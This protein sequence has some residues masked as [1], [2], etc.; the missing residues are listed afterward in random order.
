LRQ[1]LKQKLPEYM[2]PSAIVVLDEMPLTANGKVDRRA[3]PAPAQVTREETFVAPRDAIE[4]Q[5]AKLWIEML[6]L[7]Q[8]SVNDNFFDL[9]GHSL[10]A[11]RLVSRARETFHVELPLRS[12]FETATIA[13]MARAMIAHEAKPGQTEKIARFL[14]RLEAMS[15]EEVKL[16]HQKTAGGD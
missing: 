3:L 12:L 1:Y 9:G 11:S 8:V 14:K 7:K 2:V 4:E 16:A 13:E 5:L 15:A 10:L 6:G